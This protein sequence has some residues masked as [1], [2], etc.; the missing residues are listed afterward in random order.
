MELYIF[1]LSGQ[2]HGSIFKIPMLTQWMVVVTGPQLIEDVQRASD[3]QL[4]SNDAFAE[5]IRHGY[6]R[7]L[8]LTLCDKTLH[9]DILFGRGIRD[10][11]FHLDVIRS[12]LT[13]N[14]AADVQDEVAAMFTEYV[15]SMGN[16][17]YR[18]I[19]REIKS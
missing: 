6:T 2:Y 7:N 14:I 1:D 4:S 16:G 19:L 3:D 10:D 9:T 8:S 15:P 17:K 5:V 11:E 18:Q 13:R 12:Q